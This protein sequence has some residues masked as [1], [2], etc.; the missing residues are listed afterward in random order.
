MAFHRCVRTAG[1]F[2]Q[3]YGGTGIIFGNVQIASKVQRQRRG[4]SAGR[5]CRFRRKII[6]R[7]GRH[8]IH[9][10][11]EA[12]ASVKAPRSHKYHRLTPPQARG[13][14]KPQTPGREKAP[15]RYRRHL[16]YLPDIESPNTYWTSYH[17]RAYRVCPP[18]QTPD[19]YSKFRS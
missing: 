19:W 8:L 9:R 13:D 16:S 12:G 7:S 11:I 4:V 15:F 17:I 6:P 1:V 3:H 14:K 5:N 2:I 18:D 10:A